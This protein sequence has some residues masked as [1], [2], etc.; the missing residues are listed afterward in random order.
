MNEKKSKRHNGIII[1]TNIL[2]S[3]S[4]SSL[5]A[6]NT[7]KNLEELN[8]IPE[9]AISNFISISDS[10]RALVSLTIVLPVILLISLLKSNDRLMRKAFK[11]FLEIS[12]QSYK[13]WERKPIKLIMKSAA[14]LSSGYMSTTISLTIWN[15][16]TKYSTPISVNAILS[17]ISGLNALT[18]T[19]SLFNYK[20]KLENTENTQ[21]IENSQSNRANNIKKAISIITPTIYA[22]GNSA[23]YINTLKITASNFNI[24]NFTYN[25]FSNT[26]TG[27]IALFGIIGIIGLPVFRVMRR[28]Y[29]NL[30]KGTFN[31]TPSRNAS[32]SKT[33]ASR[34][35]NIQK[36]YKRCVNVENIYV[37]AVRSATISL[38]VNIII[39]SLAPNLSWAIRGVAIAGI[40]TLLSF[41]TNF[42]TRLGLYFGSKRKKEVSTDANNQEV[43]YPSLKLITDSKPNN[44]DSLENNQHHENIY[45]SVTVQPKI[46]STV[47]KSC[48]CSIL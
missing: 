22:I 1:V 4:M 5:F 2:S 25:P 34:C 47:K 26:L 40:P 37:A 35:K 30:L 19:W 18:C 7:Y 41:T 15:I 44:T 38:S 29:S 42:A 20:S 27:N 16:L 17:I 21:L 8:L 36:N 13:L 10:Q 32:S 14:I 46:Q 48:S 24:I 3:L 6:L 28:S 39:S 45:S 43:A 23:L 33:N 12:G 9:N 11:P 31:I